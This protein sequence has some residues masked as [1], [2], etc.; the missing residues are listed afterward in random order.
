MTSNTCRKRLG[1]ILRERELLS[2]EQL[3]HALRRAQHWGARLG[4]T[5]IALGWVRPVDIQRAVADQAGLPF[6]D[7]EAEPPD[8]EL[9][10]FEDWNIYITKAFCPWRKGA[11]GTICYA[12]VDPSVM[13]DEKDVY[14]KKTCLA[15]TTLRDLETALARRFRKELLD[16]ATYEL[17]RT[18]SHYSARDTLI[19]WQKRLLLFLVFLLFIGLLCIPWTTFMVLLFIFT[20]TAATHGIFRLIIMAYALVRTRSQPKIKASHFASPTTHHQS[21]AMRDKELP[22]Y[23]ILV[24]LYKEPEVLPLLADSLRKIDYPPT[25]LDIRLVL[26][27]DDEVTLSAARRARLEGIFR[28]MR[29]PSG[30]PR[31]KPK[32]CNYAL[33]FARGEFCVIFDAEDRPEPSQLREALALFYKSGPNTVCVQARLNYY[34]RTDNIITRLFT[35]E[36]T[37]IFDLLLPTF[38][39]WGLPI[40][41]GGTSNHFRTEHL[42]RLGAW[43]PFNVTED[44]DLGIRIYAEDLDVRVTSATTWEEACSQP[45][46]WFRQRSRWLKGYL[47]T[48]L[49]HMRRPGLLYKHLGTKGFLAF[50]IYVGGT[51]F[52]ALVNP[53]LWL[54]FGVM[55]FT[56]TWSDMTS[57]SLLAWSLFLLTILINTALILL[58]AITPRVRTKDGFPPIAWE[59]IALPP[60]W[61]GISLA[62]WRGFLQLITNPHYWDK[63]PHALSYTAQKELAALPDI[64]QSFTLS[65]GENTPSTDVEGLGERDHAHPRH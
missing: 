46:P 35:I 45:R 50:H 24:P 57:G 65:L 3:E 37:Q 5:L 16:A 44:A 41:L 9:L 12:C 52:V 61:I 20:F 18:N 38:D 51:V 10:R 33:R 26:E 55:L 1:E 2:E 43:D 25:K 13:F 22:I 39:E 49:V 58:A 42:R 17:W 62:A 54:T 4:E 29:V 47:Q 63:T 36:Y 11:D 19:P 32:A 59:A 64:A 23:T 56:Q 7:L 28:I 31:T 40:P 48:W 21:E 30:N 60:Y 14:S 27:E 6:V 53:F 8:P 15:I 34:N